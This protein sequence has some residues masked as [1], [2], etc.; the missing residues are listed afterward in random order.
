[1]WGLSPII[2][3][4]KSGKLHE[5]AGRKAKGSKFLVEYDSLV[6]YY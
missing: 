1:M 4:I 6:A 5:S 3:F 2:G